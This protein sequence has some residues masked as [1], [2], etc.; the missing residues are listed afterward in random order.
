MTYDE[1]RHYI[2]DRTTLSADALP[3]LML[4]SQ[5]YP[6]CSALH[7]LI[8]RALH[9]NQDL[10]FAAE[11]HRRALLI[12]DSSYLFLLLQSQEAHY[13]DWAGENN[14]PE[15]DAFALIDN[16]LQFHPQ[17]DTPILG[18]ASD[19]TPE[20]EKQVTQDYLQWMEKQ[21]EAKK[22]ETPEPENADSLITAFLNKG[23]EAETLHINNDSENTDTNPLA[24][25]AEQ[26]NEELFTETLA[27]I[28]IRQQKYA[29][30]LRIISSL[31][32]KYP[33]KNSYFAEQIK[34]LE[35]LV[36]NASAEIQKPN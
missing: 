28:Y 33:Q 22:T 23:K 31:H 5:Q 14:L 29:Q 11:L 34:Y 8:L 18:L 36:L 6:Y 16:F 24:Q 19:L 27:R 3:D 7:V 17:D 26:N 20:E 25:P 9:L 1:L 12:P 4:L 13:A 10:R 32:L 2:L 35:R 30:A 21:P 15:D